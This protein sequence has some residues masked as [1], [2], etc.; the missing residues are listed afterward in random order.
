[1]NSF[2]WNGSRKNC[3]SNLNCSVTRRGTSKLLHCRVG[4]MLNSLHRHWQFSHDDVQA[5]MHFRF[6]HGATVD[7]DP[8][9]QHS[10]E[11]DSMS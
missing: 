8:V 11:Q 4:Q 7:S 6:V 2:G 5:K 1:L 3:A 9:G 10:L